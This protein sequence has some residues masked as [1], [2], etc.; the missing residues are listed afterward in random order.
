MDL[1]K[2]NI[3]I[4]NSKKFTIQGA[5]EKLTKPYGVFTFHK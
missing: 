1:K 2:H 5:L 4:V 3:V